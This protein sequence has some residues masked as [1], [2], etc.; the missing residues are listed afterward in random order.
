[1]TVQTFGPDTTLD[2]LGL[3]ER[4]ASWLFAAWFPVA[5]RT[6]ADQEWRFDREKLR[7]SVRGESEHSGDP[8]TRGR[9]VN[10]LWYLNSF[11]PILPFGFVT[12]LTEP[13]AGVLFPIATAGVLLLAVGTFLNVTGSV[14]LASETQVVDHTTE[15]E[16]DA[17]ATLREQ[18]VDGEVDTATFEDR[19][20]EVI[21]R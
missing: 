12:A 9:I 13:P 15:P 11:I 3:S 5:N 20:E 1:M 7:L 8:F 17:V 18:Y 4:L 14:D 21:D 19:I 6:L 10:T 16:P 2:E